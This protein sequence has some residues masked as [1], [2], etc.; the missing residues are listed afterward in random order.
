MI[1]GVGRHDFAAF[2]LA[3][4]PAFADEQKSTIEPALLIALVTVLAAGSIAGYSL[5][6]R[7]R[8]RDD[9]QN[10]AKHRGFEP[11][12]GEESLGRIVGD[13]DNVFGE[14]AKIEQAVGRQRDEFRVTLVAFRYPEYRVDEGGEWDENLQE[15][16]R[17]LVLIFRGFDRP[18]P[19]FRLVPNNWAVSVL[20]G[21]RSNTFGDVEPFGA[22]NYVLGND[23]PRIR[24]LLGGELQERLG[25][26][27]MLTIE[28]RGDFL[29][30]YQHGE[31]P[32]PE[33]LFDFFE[34]CADIARRILAR[35]RQE[36]R[37]LLA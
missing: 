35:S 29:A 4:A 1:P 22:F 28:S 31:R 11:V 19:I 27:K 5:W 14:G 18:L 33:D 37:V 30:F 20:R 34:R 15:S 36:E 25:R 12:A 32:Q 21:Q 24:Q 26:N 13:L 2:T 9:L 23:Q 7:R 16:S 10:F 6:R 3:V 8:E 17:R